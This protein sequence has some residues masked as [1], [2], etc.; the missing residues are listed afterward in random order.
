MVIFSNP[1]F[2][3]ISCIIHVYSHGL[4]LGLYGILCCRRYLLDQRLV[5]KLPEGNRKTHSSKAAEFPLN[6]AVTVMQQCWEAGVATEMRFYAPHS[7]HP[8]QSLLN[9]PC[10]VCAGRAGASAQLLI[11]WNSSFPRPIQNVSLRARNVWKRKSVLAG[12]W[13]NNYR[14]TEC[15][16]VIIF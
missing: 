13:E 4:L 14:I 1:Q 10:K 7:E 12:A 5:L 3:F 9:S 6:T 11:C 2:A 15:G 16:F 8:A